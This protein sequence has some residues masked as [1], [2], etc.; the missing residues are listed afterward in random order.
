VASL[1]VIAPVSPAVAEGPTT[2]PALNV[3]FS[4]MVQLTLTTSAAPNVPPRVKKQL[5]A[6]PVFLKTPPIML[7]VP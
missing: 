4:F 3:P 7:T 5:R 6:I 1:M 2:N